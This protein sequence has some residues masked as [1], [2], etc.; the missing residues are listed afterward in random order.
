MNLAMFI[1]SNF[2]LIPVTFALIFKETDFEI[3]D[4]TPRPAIIL[5]VIRD[6]KLLPRISFAD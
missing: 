2:S 4:P 5:D 1:G 3:A 6:V